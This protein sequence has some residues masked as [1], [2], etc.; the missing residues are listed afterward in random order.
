MPRPEDPENGSLGVSPC[1]W[2]LQQAEMSLIA[3]GAVRMGNGEISLE[4]LPC[5]GR[6]DLLRLDRQCRCGYLRGHIAHEDVLQ[7]RT[8]SGK[9]FDS[10]SNYNDCIRSLHGTPS[11][12]VS[13]RHV[14]H[15]S[16]GR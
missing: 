1:F 8:K 11:A 16:M 10:I 15:T 14:Q 6:L 13:I 2:L 7:R 3:S 5:L 9:S 4:L 12:R